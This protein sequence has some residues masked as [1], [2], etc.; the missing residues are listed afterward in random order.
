[1]EPT[2]QNPY[3]VIRK[4]E[5]YLPTF[6]PKKFS[7][8]TKKSTAH[9]DAKDYA[10]PDYFYYDYYNDFWDNEDTEHYWEKHH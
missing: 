3:S 9:Y 5:D 6:S 1:M 2:D 8:S 4:I 7:S 10:H